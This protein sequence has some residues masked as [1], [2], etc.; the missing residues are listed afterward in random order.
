[1]VVAAIAAGVFVWRE[2]V[3]ARE[4]RHAAAARFVRAWEREDYAAMWRALTPS[5]RAEHSE[6]AFVAAYRSADHRAGVES[7]RAR[8]VGQEHGGKVQV[9]VAIGLG[10]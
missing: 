6:R 3:Q 2:Q 5:A 8:K 7:V 10:D 9:P 4:D 1:M